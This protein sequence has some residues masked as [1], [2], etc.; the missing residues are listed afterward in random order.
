MD[1]LTQWIESL[2]P[3]RHIEDP[4]DLEVLMS[5][6]WANIPPGPRVWLVLRSPPGVGGSRN[7]EL[8]KQ[9]PDVELIP[10]FTHAGFEDLLK[11]IDSSHTTPIP[12][13]HL[14]ITDMT[15]MLKDEAVTDDLRLAYAG[16]Y[17]RQKHGTRVYNQS[18]T[19]GFMAKATNQSLDRAAEWFAELGPRTLEYR[20]AIPPGPVVRPLTDEEDKLAEQQATYHWARKLF[21]DEFPQSFKEQFQ[22]MEFEPKAELQDVVDLLRHARSNIP[23]HPQMRIVESPNDPEHFNR[24]YAQ[25]ERLLRAY[26]I[27]KGHEKVEWDFVG[28]LA[29]KIAIDSIP[30]WRHRI[31]QLFQQFDGKPQ[32]PMALR[33]GIGLSLNPKGVSEATWNRLI[34]EMEMLG[35]L[36][37]DEKEVSLLPS[38]KK[39]LAEYK[40]EVPEA[41]RPP[42]PKD[43]ILS[44]IARRY[45]ESFI[46]SPFVPEMDWDVDE[47]G[48]MVMKPREKGKEVSEEDKNEGDGS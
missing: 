1:F 34:E 28:K 15:Y 39:V 5:N 36:Q 10:A 35:I 20:L 2:R 13:S 37:S 12:K 23:I 16:E 18:H 26:T 17:G 4:M 6:Y 48:R 47:Q 21:E 3:Y 22:E 46:E 7:L 43:D 25:L 42:T 45:E 27:L 41:F 31:I 19:F 32:H 29:K 30:G 40:E 14:I 24:P 11:S 9:F 38:W 44:I 8:F 33:V